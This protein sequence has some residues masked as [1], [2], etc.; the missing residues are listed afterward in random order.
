MDIDL[1]YANET[2]RFMG[3]NP[4]KTG[5]SDFHVMIANILMGIKQCHTIIMVAL[6]P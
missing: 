1:M 4:M 5:L 2:S 6:L 3:T